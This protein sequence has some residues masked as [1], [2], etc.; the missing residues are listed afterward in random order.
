MPV[1]RYVW[2]IQ[3]P[4]NRRGFELWVGPIGL[5]VTWPLSPPAWSWRWWST[6][7]SA[8]EHG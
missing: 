3:E 4:G 6:E 2:L 1:V 8:F 7:S 5:P